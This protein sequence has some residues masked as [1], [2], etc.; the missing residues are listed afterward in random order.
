MK[1]ERKEGQ[2]GGR[3]R[4]VNPPGVELSWTDKNVGRNGRNFW[5]LSDL[6]RLLEEK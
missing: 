6:R 3:G 5:I 1:D 4:Q 2:E